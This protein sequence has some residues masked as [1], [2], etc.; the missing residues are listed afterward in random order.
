MREKT[1][2]EMNLKS[3]YDLLPKVICFVGPCYIIKAK[4]YGDANKIKSC[5]LM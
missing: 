3:G 1:Y 4:A 5:L 2:E